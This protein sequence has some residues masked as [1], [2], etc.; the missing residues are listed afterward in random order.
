MALSAAKILGNA[1][2]DRRKDAQE[3]MV[4]MQM[5]LEDELWHGFENPDEAFDVECAP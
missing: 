2:K 5:I 4:D 1:L 3:K